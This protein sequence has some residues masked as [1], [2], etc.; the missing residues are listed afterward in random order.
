MDVLPRLSSRPILDVGGLKSVLLH[1]DTLKDILLAKS[2]A[3]SSWDTF[4]N[5][6]RLI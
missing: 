3:L 1:M 5:I 4:C 6:S 2:V